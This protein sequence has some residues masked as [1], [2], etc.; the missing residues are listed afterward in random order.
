M[1][2]LAN[3]GVD[4]DRILDEKILNIL[5]T[6]IPQMILRAKG[7]S[8]TFGEAE[9]RMRYEEPRTFFKSGRLDQIITVELENVF[10][11]RVL[12]T[13]IS[14]CGRTAILRVIDDANTVV[15]ATVLIQNFQAPRVRRAV[16]DDDPL[17]L[18]QRLLENGPGCFAK[19]GV[20]VEKWRHDGNSGWNGRIRRLIL[21][22]VWSAMGRRQGKIRLGRIDHCKADFCQGVSFKSTAELFSSAPLVLTI[23][24]IQGQRVLVSI[25]ISYSFNN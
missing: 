4:R 11:A 21:E 13:G 16:V 8:V 18:L 7:D 17:E 3:H 20:R 22:P 6:P 19:R 10:S 9:K 24:P 2:R 5:E 15:G 14:R 25:A 23:P 1:R 12:K